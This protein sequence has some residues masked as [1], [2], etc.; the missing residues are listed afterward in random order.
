MG[1][2]KGSNMDSSVFLLGLVS[3]MELLSYSM[4]KKKFFQSTIVHISFTLIFSFK[5]KN[6]IQQN[7]HHESFKKRIKLLFL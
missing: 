6:H 3:C 7:I 4:L 1:L 5:S 2:G